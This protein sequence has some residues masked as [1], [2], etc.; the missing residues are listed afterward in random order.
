MTSFSVPGRRNSRRSCRPP[1]GTLD[2]C[3]LGRTGR[4]RGA[5]SSRQLPWS[6]PAPGLCGNRTMRRIDAA[7]ARTLV[8]RH[9]T[10][11][12]GVSRLK[13]LPRP[14][15][16][17]PAYGREEQN[18]RNASSGRFARTYHDH[19]EESSS[20]NLVKYSSGSMS[21][22]STC[23][24]PSSSPVEIRHPLTHVFFSICTD[25]KTPGD[26]TRAPDSD[27]HRRRFH[28]IDASQPRR[29]RS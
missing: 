12:R 3:P 7:T 15:T 21:K 10:I 26:S 22:N 20:A 25:S 24:S 17:G 23:S 16:F 29:R 9:P 13:D 6:C 18:Q 11:G 8:R 5:A 1:L 27:R 14:K 28:A 4:G 19:V 2:F